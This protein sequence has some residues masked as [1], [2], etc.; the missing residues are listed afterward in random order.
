MPDGLNTALGR[1]NFWGTPETESRLGVSPFNPAPQFISPDLEPAWTP[2]DPGWFQTT[3]GLKRAWWAMENPTWALG[4][5]PFATYEMDRIAGIPTGRSL[6]GL[7]EYQ[8][9]NTPPVSSRPDPEF[10]LDR[11]WDLLPDDIR[12]MFDLRGV[13]KEDFRDVG[14]REQLDFN[15]L[16]QLRKMQL[17]QDIQQFDKTH[18]FATR[19]LSAT[20]SFLSNSLLTDPLNT[21]A[22][23]IPGALAGRALV[24]AGRPAL[25]AA[26][27]SWAGRA[28]T[29][30][31]VAGGLAFAEE[32]Q[33]SDLMTELTGNHDEFGDIRWEN[34]GLASVAGAGLNVFLG[35]W[36]AKELGLE[37]KDGSRLARRLS[38]AADTPMTQTGSANP[39]TLG[40]TARMSLLDMNIDRVLDELY[41]VGNPN[42]G[43]LKGRLRNPDFLNENGLTQDEVLN[44]ARRLP[45]KTD[46]D[47]FIAGPGRAADYRTHTESLL[48]DY[49]QTGHQMAVVSGRIGAFTKQLNTEL[50]KLEDKGELI[51]GLKDRIDGLPEKVRSLR[52]RLGA[53]GRQVKRREELLAADTNANGE[54]TSEI[55]E[56]IALMTAARADLAE[57][58]ETLNQISNTLKSHLAPSEELQ[59][60]I[61]QLRTELDTIRG[62]YDDLGNRIDSLRGDFQGRVGIETLNLVRPRNESFDAEQTRDFLEKNPQFLTEDG[63]PRTANPRTFLGQTLAGTG[64]LDLQRKVGS[65][66][67]GK[68]EA[69]HSSLAPLAFIARFLDDTDLSGRAL[70]SGGRHVMKSVG[71]HRILLQ[72]KMKPVHHRWR[73]LE[74]SGWIQNHG[75]HHA[76]GRLTAQVVAGKVADAPAEIRALAREVKDFLDFLGTVGRREAGLRIVK[77]FFP[78]RPNVG[79]ILA[80]PRQFQDTLQR[81]YTEKWVDNDEVHELVLIHRGWAR[82]GEDGELELTPLGAEVFGATGRVPTKVS[83]MTPEAS[84]EYRLAIPETMRQYAINAR[85]KYTGDSAIDLGDG[86][87][88]SSYRAASE[89]A[90]RLDDDI[91]FHDDM[92]EFFEWDVLRVMEDYLEN[93]GLRIMAQK[94]VNDWLGT[95]GHD[96]DNV[97]ESL[98][99]MARKQA[100]GHDDLEAEVRN[101]IAVLDEAWKMTF[102]RSAATETV[103]AGAFSTI[104]DIAVGL[105]RTA[106]QFIGANAM[107][108]EIPMN[109]LRAVFAHPSQMSRALL[110]TWRGVDFRNHVGILDE[111]GAGHNV[112]RNMYR[113]MFT[114]ADVFTSHAF[115]MSDRLMNPWRTVVEH[116]KGTVAS[117]GRGRIAGT[118]AQTSLA[119]GDTTLNLTAINYVTNWGRIMAKTG[120][121]LEIV[122]FADAARAMSRAD[123]DAQTFKGAARSSGFGG[124]WDVAEKMGEVGLL[125]PGVLDSV[126]SGVFLKDRIDWARLA[127]AIASEDNDARRTLMEEAYHGLIR[128]VNRDMN[129]YVAHPGLWEL[130]KTRFGRSPLGKLVLAF[131][132]YA[133]TFFSKNISGD[134]SPFHMS[135]F[136]IGSYAFLEAQFSL[137][138]R[139]ASGEAWED[140]EAEIN[141]DPY[142]FVTRSLERTP[143]FGASTYLGFQFLESIGSPG[144]GRPLDVGAGVGVMG[145]N[146]LL[147]STRKGLRNTLAAAGVGEPTE[148]SSSEARFWTN[149]VPLVG[150]WYTVLALRAFKDHDPDRL[151]PAPRGRSERP[152]GVPRDLPQPPKMLITEEDLEALLRVE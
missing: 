24:S 49:Q 39:T 98:K 92:A 111:V 48:W 10:N 89:E 105:G 137:A 128:L 117:P 80:A 52:G 38:G 129:R 14:N 140:L 9:P 147:N 72:M 136:L 62:V 102:H 109:V 44:F 11:E 113:R 18:G 41:G 76:V 83:Q 144:R 64:L 59:S 6:L 103:E 81:L 91:F 121:E 32:K 45:S 40:L 114:S 84:A 131:T 1:D 70:N 143:W 88:E 34:V 73:Q 68:N 13:G 37:P 141:D 120:S 152:K 86:S 75:G 47:A 74:L 106:G 36:I 118:A 61:A 99:D 21:L 151:K 56:R 17:D 28:A 54:L 51:Q 130:P 142:G 25:A 26:L 139:L 104:S 30:A 19:G 93:T 63:D 126:P 94:E 4:V 115:R 53:L 150:Q 16:W 108:V 127:N 60:R 122:R 5:R 112:T 79:R 101:G 132:S 22:A 57:T 7:G 67:T 65:F 82:R 123:F 145:I 134:P 96:L 100:R 31:T 135:L 42:L 77:D 3:F 90:R 95:R 146:H 69:V 8:S 43:S 55:H 12:F 46:W 29:G 33:Y 97:F 116:A 50:A 119:L 85:Q 107:A 66:G 2:D 149:M 58:T 125:R 78:R 148:L 20:T 15:V 87:F 138:R 124:R 27:Y 23:P 35:R 110:E 71:F 133:R